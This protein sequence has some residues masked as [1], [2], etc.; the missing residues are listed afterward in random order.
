[1]KQIGFEDIPQ[2]VEATISGLIGCIYCP[3]CHGEVTIEISQGR[4]VLTNLDCQEKP[5]CML[6][7]IEGMVSAGKE[8]E[9]R[10]G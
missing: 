3:S 5:L 6:N 9:K 10:R 8:V 1:M 4:C 2:L 7:V